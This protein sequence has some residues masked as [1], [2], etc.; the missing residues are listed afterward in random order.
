MTEN[1]E[2]HEISK[3]LTENHWKSW[4][5]WEFAALLES[6]V[7]RAGCWTVLTSF[8]T[9]YNRLWYR[10]RPLLTPLLTPLWTP[11][12]TPL[13]PLLTEMIKTANLTVFTVGFY[14][15][16]THFRQIFIDFR[17]IP[18][19]LAMLGYPD[20]VHGATTW[21]A[22]PP[23]THYP[24]TTTTVPTRYTVCSVLPAPSQRSVKVHQAPFWY[25][26]VT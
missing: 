2:N 12:S 6:E 22:P 11:L 21:S 10:L 15:K 5:I 14:R 4:N 16:L 13:P 26:R 8:M 9:V 25:Q 19:Y 18:C 17:W 23:Y 7:F 3:N 20:G 24:G 1:T